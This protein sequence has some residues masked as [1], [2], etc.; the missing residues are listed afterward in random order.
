MKNLFTAVIASIV[1]ISGSAGAAN[2][3]YPA[4]CDKSYSKQGEQSDDLTKINGRPVKCDSVLLSIQKNGNIMIQ[5]LERNSKLTPLGFAGPGFDFEMNPNFATL[6]LERIY[7][8]HASNPG[9]SQV[10]NGIE[11]FCFIDGRL[12]VKVLSGMN[13]TSKM[14][15]GTQKLIYNISVRI[16]G[17]GKLVPGS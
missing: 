8:P 4:V 15:I 3:I 17:V 9:T 11:G 5:I 1:F 7:L 2:Y 13:C 14:E 6:P 12:N 10:V 16:T